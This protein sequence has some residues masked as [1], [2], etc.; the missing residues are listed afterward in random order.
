MSF[1]QGLLGTLRT[2]L[3]SDI[4]NRIDISLGSKIIKHLYRLPLNYFS[5]RRVGEVSS[6]ISE[7]EKIRNFMTGTALTITLD[8]VFSII[9]I[10]VMLL[11]SVKLTLLSMAVIPFLFFLQYLS[12]Q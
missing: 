5:K 4:T 9:Y 1:S 8:A 3:F 7:L 11:Y 2:Y 6:R 10:I 12:L